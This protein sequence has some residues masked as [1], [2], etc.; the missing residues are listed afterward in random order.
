VLTGI[1]VEVFVGD[2]RWKPLALA[3]FIGALVC[4]AGVSVIMYAPR[5]H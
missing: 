1:V 5:G 3:Q 4:L 2:D